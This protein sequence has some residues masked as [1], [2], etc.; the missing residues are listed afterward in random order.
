MESGLTPRE[1][2]QGPARRHPDNTKMK[3]KGHYQMVWPY[4]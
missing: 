4:G 2:S 3:D 1:A